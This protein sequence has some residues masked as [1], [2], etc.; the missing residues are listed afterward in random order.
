MTSVE[1]DAG[2]SLITLWQPEPQSRVACL[3]T[4]AAQVPQEFFFVL[5]IFG[6]EGMEFKS[7]QLM[8][9]QCEK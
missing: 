3:T 7:S 6:Q 8:E 9:L 4:S 5:D 1:L 2:L